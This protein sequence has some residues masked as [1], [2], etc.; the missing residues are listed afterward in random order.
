MTDD[1][2]YFRLGI[3]GG[4]FDPVHLGHLLLAETCRE[5]C[6]LNRVLFVPCGQSPHKPN[7]ARA[8]GK[9]RAEMLELAIAGMPHFGV[10][11]IELDRSG[12]SFTVETLR[13]L[14]AEQPNAK[15]FFLM[16]ADSL[17]DLPQWREPR[18]ILELATV[19]AVNRGSQG[20]VSRE[21]LEP[22]LGPLVRERLQFVTMPAIELSATDLRDR[23]RSNR[24]LRFRVPRAVEEY[25][26][27][28]QLYLR[29]G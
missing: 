7:G 23:A 26:R 9:Q 27:Q 13:Q 1:S 24:S 14:H 6:G 16:G 2:E 4:S 18:E 25:I 29:E 21:V 19:V 3:Y 20:C 11:R 22:K 8:T 15:L 17:I 12:P 5:W 28:H 10:C